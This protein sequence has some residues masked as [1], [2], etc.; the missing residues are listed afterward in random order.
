M[1][2]SPGKLPNEV[3]GEFAKKQENFVIALFTPAL[4]DTTL[5]I[6]PEFPF[7]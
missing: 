7:C 3:N 6:S 2:E 1:K 4:G 5:L